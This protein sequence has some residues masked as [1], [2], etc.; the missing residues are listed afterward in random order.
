MIDEYKGLLVGEIGNT[1]GKLHVKKLNGKCYWSIGDW[2]G[3]EWEEI[4]Q[5]LYDALIKFEFTLPDWL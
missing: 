4:P 1:V 2:D 3:H 5:Y